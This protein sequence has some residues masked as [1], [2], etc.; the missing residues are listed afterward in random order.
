MGTREARR[1]RDWM[2]FFV[3]IDV[4]ASKIGCFTLQQ[5]GGGCYPSHR[6][7]PLPFPF[8]YAQPLDNPISP[9]PSVSPYSIYINTYVTYHPIL[10][11]LPVGKN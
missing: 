8:G 11:H 9:T 7:Y 1:K 5:V 6:S 3:K 4:L 10:L 2:G